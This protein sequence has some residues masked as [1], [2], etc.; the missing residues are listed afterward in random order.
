MDERRFQGKRE[1]GF[2]HWHRNLSMT[3]LR[4]FHRCVHRPNF[5]T[6][7]ATRANS[8]ARVKR[9]DEEDDDTVGQF[10]GKTAYSVNE[11]TA[12]RVLSD[13]VLHVQDLFC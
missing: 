8:L 13:Q 1:P 9:L 4:F 11:S 2:K 5:P 3:R 12:F 7:E 10:V 6:V